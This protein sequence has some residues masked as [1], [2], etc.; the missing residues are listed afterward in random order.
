MIRIGLRI[1]EICA[2]ILLVLAKVYSLFIRTKDL[3]IICER[4]TDA[5]DNGFWLYR[6]IQINYPEQNIIYII[7][8]DSPDREKIEKLNFNIINYKSFKHLIYLNKAKYLVSTHKNG[9]SPWP[10]PF[11]FRYNILLGRKKRVSLRHGITIHYTPGISKKDANFDLIIC[12]SKIEH[13]YVM[14]AFGYDDKTAIYTGLCRYDQLISYTCENII[15]IM[16]TWRRYLN[17]T[18]IENSEYLESFLELFS[19]HEFNKIVE[20]FNYRVIFYP[21][22]EIQPYIQLF[23]EAITN[24]NIT[25]ASKENFDV[26]EL[27]KKSGIL[28]TDYSSVFFDFA[29]MYKPVIYFQ[30][31]ECEYHKNHYQN[32][33]FD[34]HNGFG[35]CVNSVEEVVENLQIIIEN[36][37]QIPKQYRDKIDEHFVY[38][39]NK[40]CERVYNAI[41]RLKS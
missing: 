40:N 23:N 36:G 35:P 6:Y 21:H 15:L 27:L 22:H 4:G 18:N 26:Q 29:Y 5:R 2:V 20:K 41:K 14:K 37:N 1:K 12:G 13:D 19:S 39:D 31:D 10:Y 7:S 17:S 25:V 16:P 11:I 38:R 34:F 32:G 3:W 28:I 24:K 8:K 33:Y 30:F 9:F